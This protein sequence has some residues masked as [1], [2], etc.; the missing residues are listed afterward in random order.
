MNWW[1]KYIRWWLGPEVNLYFD[2]AEEQARMD[3][4][5]VK[6]YELSVIIYELG[7]DKTKKVNSES[8]KR[9]IRG[10]FDLHWLILIP[11]WVLTHPS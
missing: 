3:G 2:S 7:D 8:I 4:A 6:W 10:N 1:S 5:V 9:A 11:A